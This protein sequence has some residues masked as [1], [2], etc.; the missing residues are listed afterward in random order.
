VN[1]TDNINESM[2]VFKYKY[3]EKYIKSFY[4]KEATKIALK[5]LK[6]EKEADKSFVN[7]YKCN[8]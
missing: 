5:Q 7:L 2:F 6:E 1:N 3:L 8:E 4:S